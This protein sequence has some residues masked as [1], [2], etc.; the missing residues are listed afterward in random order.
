MRKTS[1][2]GLVLGL[3]V[4]AVAVAPVAGAAGVPA[5]VTVERMGVAGPGDKEVVLPCPTGTKLYSAGG[6]INGAPAGA[7]VITRVRPGADLSYAVV[8]ARAVN[9]VTPWSITAYVVCGEG[10]PVLVRSAPGFAAQQVDF[11]AASASCADVG[12]LTGVFG[13]V[14]DSSGQATLFGLVPSEDLTTA[15]AKG[16]GPVDGQWSV[17][18]WAVCDST[19][20]GK[21]ERET[22]AVDPN[23]SPEAT[24]QC[25]AGWPLLGGGGTVKGN[26][27]DAVAGLVGLKPD[28]DSG[29]M[30]A[31]GTKGASPWS[32]E[33]YAICSQ[34]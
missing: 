11:K 13:E 29:S 31:I 32:M 26:A 10:R 17:Q 19:L 33:A 12:A 23:W 18:A 25:A 16:S 2:W 3:A 27:P 22:S 20:I 28:W 30:T 8:G 21:T 9:A 4:V 1:M 15:T 24:A 5:R 6:W 14:V 34:P 7:A